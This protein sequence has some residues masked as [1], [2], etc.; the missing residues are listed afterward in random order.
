[1]NGGFLALLEEDED[2]KG[3]EAPVPAATP[4]SDMDDVGDDDD[5]GDDDGDGGADDGDDLVRITIRVQHILH[6]GT[7][8]CLNSH[9]M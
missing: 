9:Y 3:L 1:M 8:S 5:G 6:H 4:A 7:R 2:D